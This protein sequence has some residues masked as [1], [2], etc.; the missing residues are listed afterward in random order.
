[1]IILAENSSYSEMTKCI[2]TVLEEIIIYE[3][4]V[5]VLYKKCFY[6][7]KSLMNQKDAALPMQLML[8]GK[9][10]ESNEIC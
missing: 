6:D 4:L 9:F 5:Q 2:H 10:Y 8:L 7:V 1:M 3:C